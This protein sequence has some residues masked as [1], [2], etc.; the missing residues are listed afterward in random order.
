MRL[1]PLFA[2]AMICQNLDCFT[3]ADASFRIPIFR[4]ETVS[5]ASN[6]LPAVPAPGFAAAG[7]FPSLGPA[8]PTA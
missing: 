3:R 6:R 2:F 1:N 4:A 5:F 8:A 7:P